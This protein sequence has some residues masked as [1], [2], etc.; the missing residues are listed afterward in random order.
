MY[1]QEGFSSFARYLDYI[2]SHIPQKVDVS[3]IRTKF[4]GRRN[5]FRIYLVDGQKIRDR[6]KI[7]F[8]MGGHHWVYSFIPKNEV[9][10]D[11]RLSQ[12]D[13][14]ALVVHEITELNLMKKGVPYQ[15]SHWEANRKEKEFR[16][17]V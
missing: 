4:I 7:D 11:S 5:G 6:V 17:E 9:W 10:I 16:G 8:T 12:K 2:R 15:L 14:D 1:E 13:I 3:D